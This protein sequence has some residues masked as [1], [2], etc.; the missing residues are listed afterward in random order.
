MS[1]SAESGWFF[2]RGRWGPSTYTGGDWWTVRTAAIPRCGGDSDDAATEECEVI[3][4][5]DRERLAELWEGQCGLAE[6]KVIRTDTLA[7]CFLALGA[8]LR[9]VGTASSRR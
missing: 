3:E 6:P 8:G 5:L 4:L 2:D 1:T 9:L 7:G